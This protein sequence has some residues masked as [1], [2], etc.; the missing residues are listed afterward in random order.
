MAWN[1]RNLDKV[2]GAGTAAE[3]WVEDFL[4]EQQK[5]SNRASSNPQSLDMQ[6]RPPVP[7]GRV[8]NG[9]DPQKWMSD[10]D[11]NGDKHITRAEVGKF[12]SD[13][14]SKGSMHIH[15]FQRS[16]ALAYNFDL[17]QQL[18]DDDQGP[19]TGV[20]INDLIRLSQLETQVP[21]ND[22]ERYLARLYKADKY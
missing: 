11:F 14:F 5:S 6:N 21:K 20:S 15:D 7:P 3:P 8:H 12:E 9:F 1:E 19:E 16:S 2:H 22:L 4:A 18:S 17:I 13:T 10:L